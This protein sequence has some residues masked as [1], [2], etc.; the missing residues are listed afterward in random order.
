MGGIV[1]QCSMLGTKELG[2]KY[3]SKVK[4]MSQEG[5]GRISLRVYFRVLIAADQQ[6]GGAKKPPSFLALPRN[7]SMLAH[8]KT[9][10]KSTSHP[11]WIT[12]AL[13]DC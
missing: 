11:L 3:G 4:C 1:I 2:T 13:N 6:G 7:R 5:F 9:I 10:C 12:L 8:C